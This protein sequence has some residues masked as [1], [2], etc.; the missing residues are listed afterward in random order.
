MS[1]SYGVE[2]GES[3]LRGGAKNRVRDGRQVLQ[4][5]TNREM[6]T[7]PYLSVHSTAL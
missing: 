2:E 3:N 4:T 5:I 1:R 7:A 6:I